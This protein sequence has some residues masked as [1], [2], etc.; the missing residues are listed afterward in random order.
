MGNVCESSYS[1]DSESDIHSVNDYSKNEFEEIKE[2]RKKILNMNVFERKDIAKREYEKFKKEENNVDISNEDKIKN[3]YIKIKC[4]VL[5]DNTNKDI[6]KIYLNFIKKHSDFVAKNKLKPYKQEI[7]KYQIIFTAD[8][9]KEIEPNIKIKGQ[10]AFFLDYLKNITKMDLGINFNNLQALESIKNELNNLFLFNTPIEYDN[11]ELYYYKCYYDLIFDISN[12]KNDEIL[13]YLKNIKNVI[14]YLI[15]KDIYNNN[16]ILSNEDKM[17]LLY[18]YLLNESI[19]EKYDEKNLI[20]FN[21]LI[22]PAPVTKEDFNKF[23]GNDKE[24]KL[25][26]YKGKSFV[27]HIYDNSKKRVVLIPLEKICLKNLDNPNIKLQCNEEHYYNVDSLLMENEIDPYVNDIK[28]FLIKLINTN[29]FQQAL[30]ELFPEYINCLNSNN[31]AD[32][33]QYINERI[34]FYPFQDLDLSGVTDKLS[35]YSYVASINFKIDE[36]NLKIQKKNEDTYKVG[37]TIVNTFHEEY[38]AIRDI[39]F[40]KGN[41]KNLLFSP[42]RK[43]GKDSKGKDIESNEGGFHIEYLLFGRILSSINLLECLYIM[44]ENNYEQDLDDF[45]ENFKN[46][47]KIVKDTKGNTD[48]I[49]IKNGIFKHFYDNCLEEIEK[50]TQHLDKAINYF[51]PMMYVGKYNNV[52]EDSNYY[53]PPKK[54]GLMGGKRKFIKFS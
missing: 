37:L 39:I 17:N 46:I 8:E 47:R 10:K 20:N 11:K 7:M 27:E 54:C 32:L 49:K 2:F 48:F 41:N 15:Q 28:A 34:K 30:K 6:I 23:N 12:Q 45:R 24:N 4:L 16:S 26:I 44:N 1:K 50:I 51:I 31:N 25:V 5:I 33:R 43:V 52:M 13:E 21:R 9:M 29:V 22:Q 40:F 35:C 19:P 42:K 18:L 38:H 3:V 53:I 36:K 14:N